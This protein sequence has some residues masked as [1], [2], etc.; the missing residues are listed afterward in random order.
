MTPAK[1]ARITLFMKLRG[2]HPCNKVILAKKKF[3]NFYDFSAVIFEWGV[4]RL[5]SDS[6]WGTV[7]QA[8]KI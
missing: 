4:I 7:T 1:E 5:E 8:N 3:R 2:F 6:L